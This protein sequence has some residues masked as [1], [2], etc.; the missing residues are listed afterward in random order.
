MILARCLNTDPSLL[1]LDEPTAGVDVGARAALYRLL[2]DRAAHGLGVIVSSTD[3]EDVI[4][5]CSRAL[6]VR[7]GRIVAEFDGGLSEA[8]LLAAAHDT[9]APVTD[10]TPTRT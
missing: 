8:Q 10:R 6:V 7:G 2:I 5:T 9:V 1:L 4:R 3:M